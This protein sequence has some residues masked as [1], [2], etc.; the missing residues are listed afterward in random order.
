MNRLERAE[1]QIERLEQ[2][3]EE[4]RYVA[5]APILAQTAIAHALIALVEQLRMLVD[6]N[7]NEVQAITAKGLAAVAGMEEE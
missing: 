4:E 5:L 6:L 1:Q 2:I 3:V 7:A